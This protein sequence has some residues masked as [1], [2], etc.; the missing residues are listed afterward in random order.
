M[1]LKKLESFYD[2]IFQ[3]ED[4]QKLFLNFH[5][6]KWEKLSSEQKFN[7]LS[8]IN[9]KVASLYGY[10]TPTINKEKTKKLSGYQD[11]FN[12][13]ICINQDSLNDNPYDVIDTYFH[14]L[15]HSFQHRAVQNE[16]AGSEFASKDDVREWRRNI[17]PGNYFRAD[18]PYYYNQPLE[19]DAW[20]HGFLFAREVY[21]LNHKVIVLKDETWDDYC[22]RYR[23]LIMNMVSDNEVSNNLL[24]EIDNKINEIYD[25]HQEDVT[26]IDMGR[27]YIKEFVKNKGIANLDFNEV[28]ILLSPYAFVNLTTSNK[29]KLLNR[30]IELNKYGN[31]KLD[32]SENTVQMIRMG[33]NYFGVNS[34]LTLVNNLI[35]Y[36]F[37]KMTQD[38][39][40][41]KLEDDSLSLKA[42]NEIK[43]NLY[44]N[45]DGK[46]I[47]Y[48]EDV[49]NL[50]LFSLQPYAKY[51]S[52]YALKE[53]KRLKD[54]ELEA[55]GNNCKDWDYWERFYD[56]KLIFKT[57]SEIFDIKF[58]EYY[59]N[60]LK[61][62]KDNI[63]RD[64]V[65]NK[66]K[67]R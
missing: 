15:R 65:N 10:K 53:F 40:K 51:E 5:S 13:E 54:I 4:L 12:W 47:N 34:S 7:I 27:K 39:L 16:L 55:Y 17:F 66:S 42:I 56:N 52:K 33:G 30:Y 60:K 28:A 31:G 32:V 1:A 20:I 24:K 45:K 2:V 18:S 6:S 44:K 22:K 9:D 48:V 19:K 67:T 36:N 29:V 57:A 3:D 8:T 23:G 35:S 49:E 58:S 64:L 21:F 14:E 37:K 62:Y 25:L 38:I 43:L 50:F 59:D 26:Y 61:E 41:G 46:K 11:A 63:K